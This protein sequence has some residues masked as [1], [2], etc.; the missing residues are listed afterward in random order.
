MRFYQRCS[1]DEFEFGIQEVIFVITDKADELY[2][3]I[4]ETDIKIDIINLDSVKRDLNV[5]EG[6]FSVDE[7]GFSI[8]ELS[9]GGIV[10]NED[11]LFFCLGASN[12][13]SNRFCAI[14]LPSTVGGTDVNV[15]DSIFTGKLTN[16]ISG[17][18][19][20][21]NGTE[22]N[23]S[24]LPNRVYKFKAY[25]IDISMLEKIKM[26]EKIETDLVD[27]NGDPYDL[28]SLYKSFAP[29]LEQEENFAAFIAKMDYTKSYYGRQTVPQ[30]YSNSPLITL[31]DAI[32]IFLTG[33]GNLLSILAS[34]T[35]TFTLKESDLKLAA[36]PAAFSQTPA[37]NYKDRL[38]K[39]YGGVIAVS[40][41]MTQDV[42]KF[43]KIAPASI[44]TVP[45]TDTQDV[46]WSPIYIHRKMIEPLLGVLDN[47][48]EWHVSQCADENNYSFKQY[49]NVCEM[50]YGIAR[51]L[52]CYLQ[53]TSVDGINFDV[54]YKTI[55][56][57]IES[58]QTYLKGA[59]SANIDLSSN[60]N[61]SQTEYFSTANQLATD[62]YDIILEVTN[63]MPDQT[64]L[65]EAR[66]KQQQYNTTN[67]KKEYK[68]L[69]FS[70]GATLQSIKNTDPYYTTGVFIPINTTE[71]TPLDMIYTWLRNPAPNSVDNEHGSTYTM[72]ERLCSCLYMRSLAP[73][74]DQRLIFDD[75]QIF[76]PVAKI[77]RNVA[78]VDSDAMSLAE[79]I[80]LI[81]ELDKQYYETEYSIKLPYWN[82]FSK[83]ENDT[84]KGSWKNIKLGSQITIVDRL[85][86]WV[87]PVE[88]ETVGTW[89]E[90]T[91]PQDYI[92]VGIEIALNTPETTLKLHKSGRAA[93]SDWEGDV[94][95][96]THYDMIMPQSELPIDL[97]TAKN[98]TIGGENESLEILPGDA[99]M[100]LTD[101]TVVKSIAH[102]DFYG[103]TIGVALIGGL[104]SESIPVLITGIATNAN[105]SFTNIGSKVYAISEI[106]S[107]VSIA[108]LNVTDVMP[109]DNILV[110][111]Q[112]QDMLIE[113]GVVISEN[114]FIIDIRHFIFQYYNN[115]G[116]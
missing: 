61:S 85:K 91:K 4:S 83:T 53:V 92:V 72:M 108:T 32:Q 10:E 96:T 103:T 115:V 18:D 35:I 71:N 81:N 66:S 68:R 107:K 70:T 20:L 47:P 63:G 89:T 112:N 67:Q 11:A 45:L 26:L 94:D 73:E 3:P 33:A 31:F 1:I 100:V 98:Y 106:Y 104:W 101:G 28:V 50:L 74:Q 39:V 55:D 13:T 37:T 14:V 5:G 109:V 58:G 43:L 102:S 52:C 65:F 116:N 97:N 110:P 34:T 114:S 75:T 44:L 7:G 38:P 48:P 27:E 30:L 21:W 62:D 76:R 87:E 15:A 51:S 77:F 49:E 9:C 36:L 42:L 60:T 17:D 79:Y 40:S 57:I 2:I 12:V 16:K 24:Q 22:Y 41:G 95:K 93:Y 64:A 80:N 8:D 6:M 78:G 99:V 54:E 23:S 84:G 46:D 111:N 59:I 86:H 113:L 69:L 29:D 56:G 19:S 88:P 82:G 90:S 105:Y 25:S